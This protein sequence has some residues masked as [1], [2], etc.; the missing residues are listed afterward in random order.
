MIFIQGLSP[1]PSLLSIHPGHR[2]VQS[3][4]SVPRLG[5]FH[6]GVELVVGH[7]VAHELYEAAHELY[8]TVAP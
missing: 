1:S 8:E 3:L 4:P 6:A 7:F 5:D 2:R